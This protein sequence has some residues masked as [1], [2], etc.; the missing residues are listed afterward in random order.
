MELINS[1]TLIP[2]ID[3]AELAYDIALENNT[4]SYNFIFIAAAK[5]E[6]ASLMTLDK[7]MYRRARANRNV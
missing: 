3:P 1:C 5:E 2:S 7:K 4:T 6:K